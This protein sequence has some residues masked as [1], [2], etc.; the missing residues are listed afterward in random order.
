MANS[1]FDTTTEDRVRH[2]AYQL[3]EQDGAPEGHAD[4][5]WDRALRQIEA[6]GP[7]GADGESPPQAAS[8]EQSDKRQMESELPQEDSAGRDDPLDSPRVKRA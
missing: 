3:W 7:D 1:T 4:E 2:R 6:E 8:F 5:Y